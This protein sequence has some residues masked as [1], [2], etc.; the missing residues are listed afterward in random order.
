M[1]KLFSVENVVLPHLRFQRHRYRI[2]S[3]LH[4][5]SIMVYTVQGYSHE[6]LRYFLLS[7]NSP[8]FFFILHTELFKVFY[9]ASIFYYFLQRIPA[10]ESP[11]SHCRTA[12]WWLKNTRFSLKIKT[13][14]CAEFFTVRKANRDAG[15]QHKGDR[16]PYTVDR[17]AQS[18]VL[19]DFSDRSTWMMEFSVILM[20][21]PLRHARLFFI[22]VHYIVAHG[23]KSESNSGP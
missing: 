18:L 2:S 7:S 4:H 8:Q 17:E 15:P 20:F 6:S 19:T 3:Y 10:L 13:L 14:H 23:A 16:H 5:C 12:I 9:C 11:G 21:W 22:S 1:S